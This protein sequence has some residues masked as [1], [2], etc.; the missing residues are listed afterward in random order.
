MEKSHEQLVRDIILRMT[1]R[2][3]ESR[4]THNK[5]HFLLSESERKNPLWNQPSTISLLGKGPKFTIKAKSLTTKEVRGACAKLNYRL[6][7][8]FSRYVYEKDYN[9]MDETRRAA[10]LQPWSP[11]QNYTTPEFCRSYVDRFFLCADQRGA[12]MHNHQLSPLFELRMRELERGI[13]AAATEARKRLAAR[14]RWPNLTKAERN[15]LVQIQKRDVGYNIADKNYGAVIYSKSLFKEQCTLHLEDGK[16]TYN[17]IVNRYA[18][19]ILEDVLLKLQAILLPFKERGGGLALV[20]ESIKRDSERAAE[21]RRLCK[22]YIIWK[23]HKK[24]NSVGLRSRPIASALGYVTGP[25]SHF[26]HCQ[27]KEAVWKH[28]YVLKDST[29]LIRIVEGLRFTVEDTVM[30]N[31]ADVNALYPS[32][33]LARGMAALKWFMDHHTNFNE[34]LKDLCLKLAQF[35]L[36]NNFVA[37]EELGSA[38]YHQIIGTAMGTSFSV[39]YAIIFMIWLE[40]PIIHDPR[41][42]RYVYLY[43]RFIDDLFLIWTGPTAVLCEFRRA[44]ASAD[45]SISLDWSG[46]ESQLEAVDPLKVTAR[47]HAQ[48]NFL[49]LDMTLGREKTRMGDTVRILLRPYRKPGNAYAY[50]PFNSFHGRHI[51]RGWVL[52]ELLRLL[53]HS[54]SPAIWQE[55]TGIFFQHLCSRGYPRAFLGRVFQ[56]ITWDRR[57]EALTL[58]RQEKGDGFFET[59]RACVLTLRNAP[60]WPQLRQLMNLS[61]SQLRDDTE[62]DIFPR[63]VFLAQSNAPRLGSILKR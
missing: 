16:G 42:S 57:S 17:K 8:A 43:K 20:T 58:R 62:G 23:L 33:H 14:H 10:G 18:G 49:D 30:L 36:T 38:I 34:P 13:V 46:Y 44:M 37:C 25:A 48:V 41:F 4:C 11:K 63:K 26:L 19:D 15:A 22:F 21:S 45:N 6:V 50:V 1:P 32:I 51:F 61:L 31:A 55:E 24:A 3:L 12:W 52:A 7:R 39:V 54:S 27:L 29:E 47:R 5:V 40:T 28:P 35:V 59:Y 9:K 56:E 2:Q 60:E 53:T